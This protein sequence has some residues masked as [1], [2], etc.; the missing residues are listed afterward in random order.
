M[1]SN[2]M[3]EEPQT[4]I[5]GVGSAGQRGGGEGSVRITISDT[6]EGKKY[7]NGTWTKNPQYYQ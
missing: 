1:M 3:A 5:G 6:C 7:R 2:G 4:E